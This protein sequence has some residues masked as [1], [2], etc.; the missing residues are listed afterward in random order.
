MTKV[1]EEGENECSSLEAKKGS[2]GMAKGGKL[3][4]ANAAGKKT[5]R[6]KTKKRKEHVNRL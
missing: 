6:T 2:P 4:E 3:S 5:G 1:E